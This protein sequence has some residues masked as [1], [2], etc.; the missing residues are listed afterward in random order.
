MACLTSVF[1]F[2]PLQVAAQ[3][4]REKLRKENEE[5]Q[6]RLQEGARKHNEMLNSR[7]QLCNEEIQQLESIQSSHM[8]ELRARERESKETRSDSARLQETRQDIEQELVNFEDHVRKRDELL[9]HSNNLRRI[10]MFLRERSDTVRNDLKFDI[11]VLKRIGADEK[12]DQ[13]SI[14]LLREKFEMQYDL[15]IQKQGLIETMYESEAKT[16]LQKQQEIWKKESHTREKMLKGLI[17]DRMQ[18]IDNAIVHNEK[19]QVELNELRETHRQA[20]DSAVDRIKDLTKEQRSD[21]QGLRNA[22]EFDG[23]RNGA[24][25]VNGNPIVGEN[26]IV[27]KLDDLL[28]AE[29]AGRPK[30]GRKK[31]AWT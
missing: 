6:L 30:F 21:H 11:D 17:F 23:K 22:E 12:V 3:L 28:I 2:P 29:A 13:P 9:P 18:Q 26:G 24:G 1:T 20:I 8:A 5:R 27:Q 19:R 4:Q 14:D 31:V 16:A 25:D 15:E 10:K 7:K